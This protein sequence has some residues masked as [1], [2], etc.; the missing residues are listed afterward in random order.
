MLMSPSSVVGGMSEIIF[1]TT[2]VGVSA[3]IKHI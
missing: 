2:V 3:P 1:Q